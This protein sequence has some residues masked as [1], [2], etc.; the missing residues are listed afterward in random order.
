MAD[1]DIPSEELEQRVK[2][3][4]VLDLQ[5]A[6]IALAGGTIVAPLASRLGILTATLEKVNKRATKLGCE[7][8]R[9]TVLGTLVRFVQD[10]NALGGRRPVVR[11]VVAL[12]GVAP[13]VAGYTLIARIEHT[14]AGNLL[15]RCPVGTDDV[16]LSSFHDVTPI[17]EHC[18][19]QR[20]RKDTF[21]VREDATGKL[22][23]I[24]RNCLA[25]FIRSTEVDTALRLWK[26]L[27]ELSVSGGDDDE[28]SWGGGCGGFYPSVIE[29]LSFA[30]ASTA[31]NGFHKANTDRSTK[32]D[33]NF[34][35]NS[36]PKPEYGRAAY[37]AW[38]RGQPTPAHIVRAQ[39][40]LA[41][42][43]ALDDSSD[44]L[45]NL[46]I[47]ASLNSSERHEG[48]LASAPAAYARYIEGVVAK[49]REAAQP[50]KGVHIGV[51][52]K[53]IELGDL[54]VVRVRYSENDWGTKTIL[55]LEDKDGSAVTWFASGAKDFEAGQVLRSARATVK[56]HDEYKGRPQTV[57]SRMTWVEEQKESVA[58]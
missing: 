36:C 40:V 13:K 51:V 56:A 11:S 42:C 44:Y 41:W 23:Q 22:Q 50:P 58:S 17:C 53:R 34:L 4:A 21:V 38:H 52:G 25:D 37:E 12:F 1:F 15:A 7:P 47:A 31:T 54:T 49:Q 35:I 18:K 20:A 3:D 28:G 27:S 2:N 45:R 24:G 6:L 29:Y 46:R 9:M 14:S 43:L 5:S 8:I 30:V 32:N 10:E 26:L 39:T 16:D 55:A 48:I 19:M 57:V 33:I